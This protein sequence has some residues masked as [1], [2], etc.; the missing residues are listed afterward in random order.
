MHSIS[1]D[2][3]YYDECFFCQ[4]VLRELRSLN[5]KVTYRHIYEDQNNL[6]TL[7]AKTGRKTTP[8]LFING[9]PMFESDDIIEWLRENQ[10]KIEK[11]N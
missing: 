6:Q 11:N 5:L 3:F 1:L 7:L 4:K 9:E 8:C 2:L 10:T